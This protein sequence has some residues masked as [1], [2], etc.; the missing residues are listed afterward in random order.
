MAAT[1][2]KVRPKRS[3]AEIAKAMHIAVLVL[4]IVIGPGCKGSPPSSSERVTTEGSDQPPASAIASGSPVAPGSEVVDTSGYDRSCKTSA[5]CRIV[6]DDP[7]NHCSCADKSI[8]AT[9]VTRF[10]AATAV[11]TCGPR[12]KVVCGECRGSVADCLDGK[13]IAKPE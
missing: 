2:T 6:K 11:I 10:Q 4:A 1:R 8:A 3:A 12:Q 7:C 13:C 5:D 9:E